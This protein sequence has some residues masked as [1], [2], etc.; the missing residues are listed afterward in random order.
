M[1]IRVN[2]LSMT[3]GHNDA[4]LPSGARG[5]WGVDVPGMPEGVCDGVDGVAA[6]V[7]EMI[8]AGADVIKIASRGGFL[9][10]TDDPR[11][12]N[13]S[14]AEVDAIVRPLPTSGRR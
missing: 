11:Q 6:K 5:A 7:R 4:W 2:M 9:S 10:P 14:Q 13:F 1:Q 3:G 12:P 8:R